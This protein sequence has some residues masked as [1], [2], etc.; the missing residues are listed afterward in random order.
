MSINPEVIRV[1]IVDDHEMVRRGLRTFL[2]AFDDLEFVGEASNGVD[3]LRLCGSNQPDVVLMD[4]VMPEMDGVEATQ[5][6]SQKFPNVKVV[7]LTSFEDE[8]KVQAALTA[9]AISFVHKNI[10][11][12][13][14]GE[15]IREAHSGQSSLSSEATQA[16]IAAAT[17]PPKPGHDLTPREREVLAQMVSG[18]TNP[19]IAEQLMI[20]RSTVKTHI[21]NIFSK[22]GVSNRL[23]A[24]T[25]ALEHD[26]MA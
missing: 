9:G 19:K 18:L 14:L 5:Q 10:S 6:I 7:A 1:L 17:K 15:V 3:A 24:V 16:L 21:S 2:L 26:L 23:A 13:K 12:D 20:S 4:I 22:L 25:L 11:I 8:D